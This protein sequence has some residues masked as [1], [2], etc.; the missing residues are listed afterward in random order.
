MSTYIKLNKQESY[1]T[2]Y[3]AHKQWLL[4]N[5]ETG[6]Y[7][8][9]I[10]TALSSSGEIYP[11]SATPTEDS[12]KAELVYRSLNHLYYSN[13]QSE[14]YISA[15]YENYAQT[16][17][18]DSASR[19]LNSTAS[20]ISIPKEIYGDAIQPGTFNLVSVP[21][22][23][24]HIYDDGEGKLRSTGSFSY[25]AVT[26]TQTFT[27]IS[28]STFN[29][30][31]PGT[32]EM[33]ITSG[34]TIAPLADWELTSIAW[35]G[36][37]VNSPLEEYGERVLEITDQASLDILS[38]SNTTTIESDDRSIVNFQDTNGDAFSNIVFTFES[39]SI[40]TT[41]PA[42]TILDDQVLGDIIYTHGNAIITDKDTHHSVDTAVSYS[43]AF[44]GSYPVYT[45]NYRCKVNESQ[46]NFSQNPT[47]KSG[48]LG[49]LK[50]FATG[51]YFHPYVTTVG[52][53]NDSNELI[54]IGKMGQPI[55]KSKYM[56]MT[57][58]VKFD[59]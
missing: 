12:Q 41:R 47:V 51:S 34:I 6:S 24:F 9:R 43:L 57:F 28:S 3:T 38:F 44:K 53:Y 40:T 31:N 17:L 46:L 55:P 52:L 1:I 36:D 15:S 39:S 37:L 48:S 14:D 54:A 13:R 42:A 11:D 20:I 25:D 7:G 35:E 59:I 50:D 18:Y 32:G 58:V 5:Y 10:Y 26:S 49:Y 22:G 21:T 33:E 29:T 19:E 45:H 2:T 27:H 4:G 16:T 56:D 30:A 23:S 8:I